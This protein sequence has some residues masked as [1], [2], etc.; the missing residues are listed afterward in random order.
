[1]KK[2]F[3]SNK[4]LIVIGL[5]SLLYI[6]FYFYIFF[7]ESDGCTLKDLPDLIAEPSRLSRNYCGDVEAFTFLPIELNG[8][9]SIILSTIIWITFVTVFL[10]PI[11]FVKFICNRLA[12]RN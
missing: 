3:A 2:I 5:L 6:L 1:M 10:L 8:L 9:L 7:L 12:H 11:G 4:A